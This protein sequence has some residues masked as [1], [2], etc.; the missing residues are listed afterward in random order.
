M[1]RL[2]RL[3]TALCAALTLFV[4]CLSPAAHAQLRIDFN[5]PTLAGGNGSTLTFS[6]LLTNLG[7]EDVLLAGDTFLLEGTGLTLDDSPFL[8]SFPETIAAGKSVGG[9]FFTVMLGPDP[10]AAPGIYTGSFTVLGQGLTTGQGVETT[11][12]FQVTAAPEPAA[13]ALLLSGLLLC[14]AIAL[15]PRRMGSLTECKEVL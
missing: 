8:L 13:G 11:A 5:Q 9:E 1:K 15:R 4:L 14:G 6:G 12:G 2:Y 3:S 10:P 7:S